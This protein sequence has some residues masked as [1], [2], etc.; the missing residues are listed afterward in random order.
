MADI[1]LYQIK[2]GQATSK[3]IADFKYE[4]E[5]QKLCEQNLET[6][7]GIRFLASEYSTGN[8][9]RGRIDSLGIDENNCPVI[10]EYKLVSKENVINQGL[11]YLDWLMDH[12]ANFEM[13]CMKVL[14]EQIE[15]DWT[16]PR[17]V[18]IA[19]DFTRYDD[20]AI[21]Q[22]NRNIE[23]IRYRLFEG[24]NIIFEQAGTSQV[25][26]ITKSSSPGINKYRDMEDAI[27][28]SSSELLSLYQELENYILS[29]GD[30]IQ[31]KELKYYH[32]FSRIKNFV[33]VEIRSKKQE[34]VLFLKLNYNEIENPPK[35][36]RDVSNI[37]HYGTGDTEV[38]IKSIQELEAI[39]SLIEESYDNG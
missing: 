20:Y 6:F 39:K 10:I 16:N 15:V 25:Q 26:D 35:N 38:T 34:L 33:C 9:H 1:K 31:K 36:S 3:S 28:A 24:G 30:D 7:F 29:L 32:A 14:K 19:K 5:I 37:G 18:C 22:I 11:F 17:L 21:G 12:Q 4:S 13:L 8:K 2:D 23:L 27:S